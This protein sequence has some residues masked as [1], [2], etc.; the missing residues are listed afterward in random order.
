MKFCSC[1][2]STSRVLPA[3]FMHKRLRA[4][5]ASGGVRAADSRP[6][7][8]AGGTHTLHKPGSGLDPPCRWP[9][10]GGQLTLGCR[11]PGSWPQ[12]RV[13]KLV[14]PPRVPSGRRRQH[15]AAGL[16]LPHLLGRGD[17]WP[18]LRPGGDASLQGRGVAH[19]LVG[20]EL[21]GA[22]LLPSPP[23]LP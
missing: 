4:V 12:G 13:R 9:R 8:E 23:G 7:R 17:G 11:L 6:E 5:S 16:R 19:S 10:E 20:E 1:V 2:V 14:N 18:P 15:S 21:T 3:V 22:Q